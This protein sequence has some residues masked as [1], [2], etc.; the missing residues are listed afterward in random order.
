MLKEKQEAEE[1]ERMVEEEFR[2]LEKVDEER[3]K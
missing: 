2:K 1:L 3:E